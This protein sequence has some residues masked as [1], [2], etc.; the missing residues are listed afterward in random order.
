[1]GFS[2]GETSGQA[3]QRKEWERLR[4]ELAKQGIKVDYFA[5]T[6]AEIEREQAN[7]R[8]QLQHANDPARGV[9]MRSIGGAIAVPKKPV[10]SRSP[11][12]FGIGKLGAKRKL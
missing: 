9:S 8:R 6:P 12:P 7:V 4:Q 3:N 5:K 11:K 10:L 2:H 1:M